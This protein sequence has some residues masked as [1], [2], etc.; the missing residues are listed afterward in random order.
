[1][2]DRTAEHYRR[3]AATYNELWTYHPDYVR[4]FSHAMADALRLT[5]TDAIVDIWWCTVIYTAQL[6]DDVDPERPVLCVE[7][8][9]A[10]LDQLPPSA[11]LL[12]LVASAEDLGS[13]RVALPHAPAVDAIILKESVHHLT[14]R[15]DTLHGLVGLLTG[16][17]RVLVVMLPK[18]IEHPLFHAAHER[19]QQ[20]QPDPSDIEAVLAA[21]GLRTSVTYRRFHVV[22]ERERYVHMLESRYM[23][24]LGDFTE[25]ELTAGVEQ[26]RR[27]YSD[28]LLRFDDHF[29]FVKGWVPP[30]RR[31]R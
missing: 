15:W 28:P 13:G 9:P 23:S 29:V 6:A 3:T 27:C 14:N 26:F 19:F 22:I 12:P 21:A 2:T 30:G 16:H 20:L 24:V 1:M 8:V 5:R 17:G 31:T 25:D 7:P 10:M 18:V 11:K 4:R